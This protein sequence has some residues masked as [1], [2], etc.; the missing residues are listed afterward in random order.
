MCRLAHHSTL[1]LDQLLASVSAFLQSGFVAGEQVLGTHD[2][3]TMPCR[4]I[5]ARPRDDGV[6]ER[7]GWSN[8]H[9]ATPSQRVPAQASLMSVHS[10]E[11]AC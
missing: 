5:A 2:G 7:V 6:A 10:I 1:R 8:M 3:Q 9:V 4:I 11:L